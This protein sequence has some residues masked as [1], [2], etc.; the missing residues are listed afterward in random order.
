VFVSNVFSGTVTRIDLKVPRRGNNVVVQ[1]KIQIASGY[2]HRSDPAAFV[3]GPTGLAYDPARK[4]LYVASTGDNA[5]FAIHNAGRTRV[6]QG[7]GSLVNHD[8]ALLRG[9]L[10]LA[11]APNGDLL[12]TNGDAVNGDPSRPSELVEF[13]P[14]GGA[15]GQLSLD[16][17][18]GA[19]FGLAMR[20]T[21][22]VLDLVTVNDDTNHLDER[23]VP[24]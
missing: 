2:L 10:G 14:M 1:D 6:D 17:A 23:F 22:N 8:P 12:T 4:I 19:A 18:Q 5:I 11:L 3:V 13:T 7:M 24:F 16:P 21:N 9:P 20:V 15:I